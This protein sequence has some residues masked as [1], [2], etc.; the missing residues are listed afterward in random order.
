MTA[1]RRP[2]LAVPSAA[3][4]APPAGDDAAAHAA[5]SFERDTL[6]WVFARLAERTLDQL[7][8]SAGDRARYA[9][10]LSQDA[11][12]LAGCGGPEQGLCL[13]DL[14]LEDDGHYSV[15]ARPAQGEFVAI[16][17]HRRFHIALGCHYDVFG[18]RPELES[19]CVAH[20]DGDALLAA[21]WASG[22]SRWLP[23]QWR[24]QGTAAIDA[25]CWAHAPLDATDL[26]N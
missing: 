4:F 5:G 6:T 21:H 17:E 7:F 25:A 19:V 24:T 22:M 15:M 20:F 12:Q 1:S 8:K 16:V 11:P 9:R 3:S 13:T 10:W 18:E 2:L 26:T 14:E 23:L